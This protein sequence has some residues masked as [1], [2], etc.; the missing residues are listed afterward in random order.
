MNELVIDGWLGQWRTI[1]ESIS[2]I[3]ADS[4]VVA[5]SRRYAMVAIVSRQSVG[6]TER[7]AS[8]RVDQSFI[9]SL[10]QCSSDVARHL[11]SFSSTRFAS[12]CCV[13]DCRSISIVGIV[14]QSKTKDR[15]YHSSQK[16]LRFNHS[17]AIEMLRKLPKLKKQLIF[18]LK[19]F[20]I[21][22]MTFEISILE[23]QHLLTMNRINTYAQ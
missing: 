21:Q 9:D 1:C 16:E 23:H 6:S 8:S 15:F 22:T 4:A 11:H 19:H 13:G 20:R 17:I 2:T 12:I 7:S 5:C 10:V 3:L 18:N 14:C